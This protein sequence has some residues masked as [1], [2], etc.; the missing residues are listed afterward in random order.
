MPPCRWRFAPASADLPEALSSWSHRI[1]G[2]SRLR[3]QIACF[4][5]MFSRRVGV[6]LRGQRHGEVDVNLGNVRLR[7]LRRLEMLGRL[8]EIV[9]HESLNARAEMA[10][11]VRI[12]DLLRLDRLEM[13][14]EG[15]GRRQRQKERSKKSNSFFH[16]LH[17]FLQN[18]N[19][20]TS[21]VYFFR[22]KGSTDPVALSQKGVGN[23]SKSGGEDRCLRAEIM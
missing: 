10:L 9:A 11:R 23:H 4:V 2:R 15:G 6:P 19:C 13:V 12:G 18:V 7:R 5:E 1:Q 20:L 17:A 22:R 14:R 8:V 3:D 21:P 16:I